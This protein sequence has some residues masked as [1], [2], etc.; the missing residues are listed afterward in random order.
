MTL[1]LKSAS[2]LGL[3]TID[4][5]TEGSRSPMTAVMEFIKNPVHA[6]IGISVY[7]IWFLTTRVDASMSRAE[8]KLEAANVA[9]AALVQANAE[10]NATDKLYVSLMRQ[11]CIGVNKS[12]EQEKCGQ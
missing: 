6:A 11:I 7:L 12:R 3:G 4:P 10:R 9:L 8:A 5:V 2:M 1:M